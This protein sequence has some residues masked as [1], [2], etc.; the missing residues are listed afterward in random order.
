MLKHT[1]FKIL[2]LI[3]I[4]NCTCSLLLVSKVSM[5]KFP[6]LNSKFFKKFCLYSNSQASLTPNVSN[7]V[8]GIDI[9]LSDHRF[10]T[11][12]IQL[13]SNSSSWWSDVNKRIDDELLQVDSDRY[14]EFGIAIIFRK[15]ENLV[16]LLPISKGTIDYKHIVSIPKQINAKNSIFND[17]S[18]ENDSIYDELVICGFRPRAAHDGSNYER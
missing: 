13:K 18:L 10:W 16:Q 4:F 12:R 6:K 14:I 9:Y 11:Q 1:C 5:M 3:Y 8:K 7:F 17:D 15:S 2:L